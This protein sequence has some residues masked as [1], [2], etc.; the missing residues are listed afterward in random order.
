L[1]KYFAELLVKYFGELL[2]KYFGELLAKLS[3]IFLLKNYVSFLIMLYNKTMG[4]FETALERSNEIEKLLETK[5]EQFRMLTGDRP[6]GYLHIGHLFGSIQNRVKLQNKGINSMI[7]IADYQVITDRETTGNI[8]EYVYNMVADYIAAGIIPIENGTTASSFEAGDCAGKSI[9]F[10]HSQIAA[11]NQLLIPFLSLVTTAE[12]ERN[13]TIKT[14]LENSKVGLSGLLLTYPV[15]QAADILFCKGNLVPVGKDQLPHIEQTRVVARR[16]NERYAKGKPELFPDGTLFPRVDALLSKVIE[17][18]GADGRK[19]SKSYGNTVS[20]NM[21]EDETAKVIKK[22]QSDSERL[23]TF[24][25]ENRPGVSALLT[26]GSLATG[27]T[28]ED[29]ATEIGDAGAGTLKA[30]VTDSMNAY[31]APHRARRAEL[32]ADRGELAR[33]LAAGNAVA[34]E[35]AEATLLEVKQ[36]MGTL[37]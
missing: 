37:Y 7:L 35:I 31:L 32:L 1:A 4:T 13:P 33:I 36:A 22:A 27:R 26:W 2:V 12:L 25:P 17:V 9:I 24:D 19:M 16:F 34:S 29:I 23:I 20:L 14:E 3:E 21:T 10:T 5:P 30:F 15:H 18:P 28:P 11:L 6:T 8:S